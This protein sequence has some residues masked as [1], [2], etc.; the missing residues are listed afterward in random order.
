MRTLLG[1]MTS[2]KAGYKTKKL[3]Q[4]LTL[5]QLINWIKKS[6]ADWLP[7]LVFLRPDL[8]ADLSDGYPGISISLSRL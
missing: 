7:L 6:M 8:P 4:G 5:K 2:I 3:F 1:G